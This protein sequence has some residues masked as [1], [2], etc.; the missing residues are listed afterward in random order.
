[1]IKRN[2]G[3]LILTSIVIMLPVIIG[4]LLWNRLPEQMP[5]HWNINGEVDSWSSKRVAVFGFPSLVLA[6]HWL[7]FLASTADPKREAYTKKMLTLVLWICPII[8]LLVS[9]LTYSKALGFDLSVNIIM[10]LLVGL[11]FLVIGNLLPKM[12]QSYTLGIKLPWTLNNEENWNKTHRFAGKVWV[13]CGLAIL[14]SIFLPLTTMVAVI[15]CAIIAVVLVPMAYSYSIYKRHK[16][17]G[18]V[19]TAPE[20]SKADKIAAKISSVVVPLI[21]I[22]LVIVMFTGNITVR[23]EDTALTIDATYWTDLTV[24]Y[25]EIDTIEYRKDFNAGIRAS[26]FASA[27][28]SLGIFENEEFGAYTLYAYTGAT[29]YIVLTSGEKI[30]VIGMRDADE[31]QALYEAILAKQ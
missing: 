17:E 8:S 13:V 11:M 7:C 31:T 4:L 26:G 25:S 28:L 19:Y 6:L 2:K 3:I 10:P 27:R 9:S 15:I 14:L 18:I 23:C 24:D 21:C 29:E 12:R 20:K 30:L 1:M 22:G 5:T 16:K